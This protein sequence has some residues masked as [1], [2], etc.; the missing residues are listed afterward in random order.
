[1]SVAGTV[2]S[3]SE[4]KFLLTSDETQVVPGAAGVDQHIAIGLQALKHVDLVQQHGVLHDE[5]IGAGMGSRESNLAFIDAAKRHHRRAGAL[6]AECGERLGWG[7]A[8]GSTA[9]RPPLLRLGRPAVNSD[10]QHQ[11]I[12]FGTREEVILSLCGSRN[13]D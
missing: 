1:M 11:K 2:I 7:L 10:L 6:G 4:R 8:G 12:L 5:Y 9:F 13:I 3:R